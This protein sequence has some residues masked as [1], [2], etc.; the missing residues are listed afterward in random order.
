[1]LLKQARKRAKALCELYDGHS[2][3]V[4]EQ[5]KMGQ[6]PEIDE[7]KGAEKSGLGLCVLG[8]LWNWPVDG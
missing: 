4:E 1:L 3:D 6:G 5:T 7:N 2:A 8:I